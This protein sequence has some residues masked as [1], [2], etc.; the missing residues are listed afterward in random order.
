MQAAVIDQL[1]EVVGQF[2]V[3]NSALLFRKTKKSRILDVSFRQNRTFSCRGASFCD[4]MPR[5]LRCS[6]ASPFHRAADVTIGGKGM[7]RSG[8]F[9]H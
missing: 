9:S 7:Q 5:F 4:E 3:E 2:S 6:P 8:S 1:S